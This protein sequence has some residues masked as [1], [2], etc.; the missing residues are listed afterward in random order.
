[1][2]SKLIA[3][4]SG[5]FNSI[6]I[7]I[8][9]GKVMAQKS[10]SLWLLFVSLVSVTGFAANMNTMPVPVHV[11]VASRV[12]LSP[13][14][15]L[16]ATIISSRDASIANEIEG[17]IESLLE[18]GDRVKKGDVIARI[19]DVSNRLNFN[20][21]K[22]D[23]ASTEAQLAFLTR[24]VGRLNQLILGD[25]VAKN[26]LDEVVTSQDRMS[27]ELAT[28]QARLE[29]AQDVLNKSIIYAPFPG[30]IV[31]RFAQIG[32]WLK[33]GD[34][35][36]HLVDLESRE[37]QAKV[38]YDIAILLNKEQ[39]MVITDGTV[40]SN[41]TVKTLIPFTDNASRMYEV[42]LDFGEP[43]WLVGH[44]LRVHVPTAM[45]QEIVAVPRDALVVRSDSTKIFRILEDDTAEAIP[46]DIGIAH[47]D[48]VQVIGAVNE[49]DKIVVR[50][51]ERLRPKQKIII[52]KYY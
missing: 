17:Q 13:H 15:W 10:I 37:I 41:A 27:G 49:G 31:E 43:Q 9:I 21:V 19:D 46:V 12:D 52:Q 48:L 25:N 34:E 35:L 42:R 3:D 11:A 22:A 32:E 28:K 20:A 6:S 24:E 16:P 26:K 14:I 38:P 4:Y 23:I 45:P 47:G 29:Q 44:A 2:N 7:D 8:G 30:V 1:M 40:E 36:V 39:L 50:G 51:N 5:T 33:V 18:V